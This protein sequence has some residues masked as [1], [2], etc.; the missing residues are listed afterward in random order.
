MAVDDRSPAGAGSY[1]T[2]VVH[3][4][5]GD[6][7]R[8]AMGSTPYFSYSVAVPDSNQYSLLG[9]R[10]FAPF[11]VTQL[12]GAFNDNIF[13]NGLIILITFQGVNVLGMNASEIA[14]VAGALFYSAVFP[15]FRASRSTRR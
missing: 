9:Q 2:I 5:A 13:R 4:P 8:S 6:V 15:L 11:F 14:N 3:A 7:R 10:R 1:E 12:L